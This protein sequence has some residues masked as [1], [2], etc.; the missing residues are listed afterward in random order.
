[1]VPRGNQGYPS[2]CHT[3]PASGYQARMTIV[4][5]P[6]GELVVPTVLQRQAGMKAGERVEIRVSRRTMVITAI[7]K[8]R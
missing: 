8:A 3:A 7:R 2:G 4:V 6:N 5:K 1:M